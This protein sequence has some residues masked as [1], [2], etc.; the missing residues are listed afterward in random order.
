[1]VMWMISTS[2]IITL[3]AHA[4]RCLGNVAPIF[5]DESLESTCTQ[6]ISPA[7]LCWSRVVRD[8]A[9]FSHK[10]VGFC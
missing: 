4:P 10:H 1:M 7:D 5:S 9:A 6:P 2:A 8:I 3:D